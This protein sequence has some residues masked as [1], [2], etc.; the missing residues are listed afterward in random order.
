MG[1]EH[2]RAR[3]KRATDFIQVVDTM[4]DEVVGRVGDLSSNGMM[5]LAPRPLVDDA[6]Y[7]FRFNLPDARH[8]TRRIEVGAHELWATPVAGE[9]QFL[10]GYRFIDISPEDEALLAA[11]V[12]SPEIEG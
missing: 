2:R 7:Q 11:W 1:A 5:M 6:L 9:D 3:R 10:C 12:D 8:R 4:T